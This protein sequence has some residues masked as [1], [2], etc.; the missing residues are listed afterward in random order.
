MLGVKERIDKFPAE[1]G[2]LSQILSQEWAYTHQAE[3]H[4]VGDECGL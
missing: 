1:P 2:A 3:E 4:V